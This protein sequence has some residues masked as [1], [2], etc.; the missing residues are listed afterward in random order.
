MP[1]KKSRMRGKGIDGDAQAKYL[2]F[3]GSYRDLLEQQKQKTC[4]LKSAAA[5]AL[6]SNNRSKASSLVLQLKSAVASFESMQLSSIRT[7]EMYADI[8][9]MTKNEQMLQL[10][11]TFIHFARNIE[12][13]KIQKSANGGGMACSK[14][15]TVEYVENPS[16]FSVLLPLYRSLVGISLDKELID[17][18]IEHAVSKGGFERDVDYQA[19]KDY[20]QFVKNGQDIIVSELQALGS[21]N[22]LENDEL[23]IELENEVNMQIAARRQKF[24]GMIDDRLMKLW[25]DYACSNITP[26]DLRNAV[27]QMDSELS[28]RF[29]Q[30]GG[31]RKRIVRKEKQK[32]ETK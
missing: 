18:I 25:D 23:L 15:P 8:F 24:F 28:S 11:H 21:T 20:Q 14:K 9:K 3:E 6:K 12:P 13:C 7:A 29:N 32:T 5:E 19:L 26:K 17:Y 31:K 22:V 16:L 4:D 30:M 10:T 1:P 27:L 2:A